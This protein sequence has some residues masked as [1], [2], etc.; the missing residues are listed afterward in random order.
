MHL[1]V[2]IYG[3][4]QLTR[5]I[6]EGSRDVMMSYFDVVSSQ[7]VAGKRYEIFSALPIA[8]LGM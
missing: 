3:L 1:G 5:S 2:Y 8:I 4:L 6:S 7:A